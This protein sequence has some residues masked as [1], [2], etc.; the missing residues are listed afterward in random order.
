MAGP[1]AIS[2]PARAPEKQ[3]R[4]KEKTEVA[5]RNQA[6]LLLPIRGAVSV[7][8][9]LAGILSSLSE[10]R[11]SRRVDCE[12]PSGRPDTESWATE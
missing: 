3:E 12:A 2:G 9:R 11:R 4:R 7:A 5:T 8:T 6:T 1:Y 10:P